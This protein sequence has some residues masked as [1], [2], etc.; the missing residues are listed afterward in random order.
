MSRKSILLLAAVGIV[1]FA[2]SLTYRYLMSAPAP[3]E[4]PAVIEVPIAEPTVE[5]EDDAAAGVSAL[6]ETYGEDLPPE[7][8]EDLETADFDELFNDDPD[9]TF[10]EDLLI[11]DQGDSS[12][13]VTVQDQI[14]AEIREQR[15]RDASLNASAF[16]GDER[17]QMIGVLGAYAGEGNT[18]AVAELRRV[19]QSTDGDLRAD[20]LEAIAELLPSSDAVPPYSEEP[21]S[22]TEVERLIE[23]LQGSESS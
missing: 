6:L 14:D 7:V 20:A 19:L 1:A 4:S 8:L 13:Y 10:E 9:P 18:E 22:D 23:A 11:I 2:A 17:L 12:R 5:D 16:V 21:L 3:A 15:A